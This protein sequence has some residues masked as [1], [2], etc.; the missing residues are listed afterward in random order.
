MLLINMSAQ[1]FALSLFYVREGTVVLIFAI[2]LAKLLLF[3]DMC[4]EFSKKAFRKRVFA[5]NMVRVR[6]C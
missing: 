2:L 1:H 5:L 4:K 6:E 3:S